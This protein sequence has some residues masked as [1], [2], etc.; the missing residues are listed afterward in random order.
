MLMIKW[1]FRFRYVTVIMNICDKLRFNFSIHIDIIV[2]IN[3]YVFSKSTTSA[4]THFRISLFKTKSNKILMSIICQSRNCWKIVMFEILYMILNSFYDIW[5]KRQTRFT[6]FRW[7][8]VESNNN[9]TR[10]NCSTNC[11]LKKSYFI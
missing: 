10:A 4:K 2:F 3:T 6:S 11:S 7:Y 8:N 9:C 1:C 5:N